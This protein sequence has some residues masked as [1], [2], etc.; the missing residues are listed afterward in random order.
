MN[1]GFRPPL[2]K[3][4][5][6]NQWRI[7]DLKKRG[8]PGVLGL[9]PK[10]FLKILANLGDFLKYLPKIGGGG[11]SCAPSLLNPPLRTSGGGEMTLPSDTEFDIRAP[12]IWGRARYSSVTE[13]LHNIYFFIGVWTRD[14][15]LSKHAASTTAPGPP[16]YSFYTSDVQIVVQIYTCK[17]LP[18][19]HF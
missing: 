12:A 1:G 13:A 4:G 15:R 10:I 11:A 19:V 18:S 17:V 5:P 14:L 7:Q 2:G 3:L 6:E 16:P 9:A 8:A